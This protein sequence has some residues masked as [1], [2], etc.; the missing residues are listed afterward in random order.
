M[1]IWIKWLKQLLVELLDWKIYKNSQIRSK[2]TF[3]DYYN[4]KKIFKK[5]LR[6][7]F[8]KLNQI[9]NNLQMLKRRCQRRLLLL[10]YKFK[11]GHRD[12]KIQKNIYKKR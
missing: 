6:N 8:K 11:H 12:I 9:V 2:M 10:I 3:K 7:Q 5:E 4:Y 1:E